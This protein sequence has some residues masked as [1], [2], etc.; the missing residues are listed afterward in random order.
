MKESVLRVVVR[1]QLGVRQVCL[2]LGKV[3]GMTVSLM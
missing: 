2:G 1:Y 3:L